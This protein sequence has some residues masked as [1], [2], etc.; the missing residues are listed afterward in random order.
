VYMIESGPAAGVIAA[1]AFAAPHG[2]ANVI[3]FDMGGTTAKVGLIQD[4]Q[5]KLSTEFEVGGQAITPLGEGRG[6]GY[7]VRTPVIDL[8]E[9]GADVHPPPHGL[10]PRI[11]GSYRLFVVVACSHY[12]YANLLAFP[13]FFCLL[14]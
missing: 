4:G 5:L 3:S 2:Y 8:I 6:S 7:P 11:F 9:V 13:C 10:S 14:S 12:F 1:G